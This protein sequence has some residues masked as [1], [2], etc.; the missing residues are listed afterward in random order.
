MTDCLL[1]LPGLQRSDG[2]AKMKMATG[3]T[4]EVIFKGAHT[5][6]KLTKQERKGSWDVD[7]QLAQHDWTIRS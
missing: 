1:V 2:V 4:I 6:E 3:R 5:S 7:D